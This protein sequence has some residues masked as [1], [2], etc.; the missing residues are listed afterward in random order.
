MYCLQL[1][2]IKESH[3]WW[4]PHSSHNWK[5][6]SPDTAVSSLMSTKST[7]SKHTFKL[8]LTKNSLMHSDGLIQCTCNNKL[9]L[10]R[11]NGT[12]PTTLHYM[13]SKKCLPWFS[14]DTPNYLSSILTYRYNPIYLEI[15]LCQNTLTIS[16]LQSQLGPFLII[17]AY[18]TQF[19]S[20]E[21][22]FFTV[23]L[24]Q[25][26]FVLLNCTL[27]TQLRKTLKRYWMKTPLP[28]PATHT[29]FFIT[30]L[31]CGKAHGAGTFLHLHT[32]ERI[33]PIP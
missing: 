8:S 23:R 15:H 13:H 17:S 20:S 14:P 18:H 16:A 4:D 33:K 9:S 29:A 24:V 19:P 30:H 6:S 25:W 31:C 21:Q 10:W 3:C 7:I 28:I 26:S 11:G 22:N 32:Y 2:R 12:V 27:T 1:Q 5:G